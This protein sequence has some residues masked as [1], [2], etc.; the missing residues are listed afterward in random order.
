MLLN[1]IEIARTP[2]R[3]LASLISGVTIPVA[4]VSME[5]ANYLASPAFQYAWLEGQVLN[6]RGYRYDQTVQ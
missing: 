5:T 1:V 3:S 6:G 2:T 4:M